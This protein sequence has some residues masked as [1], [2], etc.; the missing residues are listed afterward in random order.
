M[1]ARITNDVGFGGLG[2]DIRLKVDFEPDTIIPAY[3]LFCT[4]FDK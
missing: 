1:N 4:M 2:D 3:V